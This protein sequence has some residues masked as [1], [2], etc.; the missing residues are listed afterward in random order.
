MG[1]YSTARSRDLRIRIAQESAKIIAEEGVEDFLLAKRK[2]AMRLGVSERNS[3]LPNNLEI[4]EA[5]VEYQRLF[6]SETQSAHVRRLRETAQRAMRLFEEF[7]PRLVGPVLSGVATEYSDVQLHLFED[8]PERVV[9]HLLSRD[10]PFESAAR[11]YRRTSGEYQSVP[12][13]RF[14]AGD[15]VIDAAVFTSTDIRQSPTSPVDGKPMKRANLKEL[16]LLLD[17][18]PGGTA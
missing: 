4:E 13:Y 14:V 18:E 12:V 15:I 8:V 1:K 9:I 3:T 11:R 6:K 16:Q 10:I 7:N 2:A 5:L 17:A